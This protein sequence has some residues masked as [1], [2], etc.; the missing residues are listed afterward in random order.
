LRRLGE[1]YL[2]L[3]QPHRRLGRPI[4]IDKK[5]ANFFHL[6]LIRLILPRARIVEVRRA[7]V[8][9][10]LSIFKS[11]SSKGRLSLAE[12]GRY[13]RDYLSLMDHFDALWPGAIQRVVYED[14][15][16]DPE[17][18]ARRLLAALDLP[19]DEACLRFHEHRRAVLTPSSEQV[20]QP[21]HGGAVAQW[22]RFEPWLGPLLEALG[23]LAPP[24]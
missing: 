13:H 3:L 6:G 4:V 17:A 1:R 23:P 7:P 8:A 14:L 15:V 5:P 16:A 22:R 24:R 19:F 9:S 11:F 21:I 2:A 20:R 10:A 12:L 18:Q